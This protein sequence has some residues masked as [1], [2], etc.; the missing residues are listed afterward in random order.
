MREVVLPLP[1]YV[2]TITFALLVEFIPIFVIARPSKYGPSSPGH[3]LFWVLY[4]FVKRGLEFFVA[5]LMSQDNG[6]GVLKCL[7]RPSVL[8]SRVTRQMAL[9]SIITS[10]L[11]LVPELLLLGRDSSPSRED[12]S[13]M[14]VPQ[15]AVIFASADTSDKAVRRIEG[16]G[17]N[18]T[19]MPVWIVGDAIALLFFALTYLYFVFVSQRWLSVRRRSVVLY[20]LFQCAWSS[21]RLLGDL[22]LQVNVV[23]AP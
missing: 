22:L 11:V 8:R 1:L 18:S 23:Y 13:K 3:R 9:T 14:F 10:G 19:S 17:Q 5:I 6:L 15:A 16:I 20:L 12:W 21:L 7:L 4:G 2:H